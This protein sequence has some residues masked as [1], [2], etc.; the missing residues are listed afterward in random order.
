MGI[1]ILP[2]ITSLG[3]PDLHDKIFIQIQ[4]ISSIPKATISIK[5]PAQPSDWSPILILI[6]EK[7]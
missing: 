6:K 4:P 1:L 3:I 7:T 5:Q 2:S